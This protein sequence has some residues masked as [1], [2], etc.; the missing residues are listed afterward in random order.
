MKNNIL[1]EKSYLFALRVIKLYRFL[2]EEKKEFVLSKQILRSGTSIWANIEESI[3]SVSKKEFLVKLS[4]AYKEAR[5]T[6]YWIKLLRDSD[7]LSKSQSESIF[8]DCEELCR[9]IWSIQ[10]TMKK[11]SKTRNS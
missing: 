7:F 5:E 4:I 10:I 6:C 9:I 8:L 3:S 1:Q 2:T 11:D